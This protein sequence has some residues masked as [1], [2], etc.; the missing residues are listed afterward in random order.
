[1]SRGNS[2]IERVYRQKKTLWKYDLNKKAIE[3]MGEMG[4]SIRDK[5]NIKE[6][7]E[8]YI[9]SRN[10]N[11]HVIDTTKIIFYKHSASHQNK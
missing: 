3:L 10:I 7:K 2:F 1:M 4:E 6:A 9:Q 11:F 8:K 5:N